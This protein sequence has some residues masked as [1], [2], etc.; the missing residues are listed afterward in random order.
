MFLFLL[1]LLF[2]CEFSVDLEDDLECE[3]DLELKNAAE[4]DDE[5]EEYEGD[6]AKKEGFGL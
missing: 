1:D 6:G 3:D 4:G 5:N 2:I